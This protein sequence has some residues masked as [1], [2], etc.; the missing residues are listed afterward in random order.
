MATACNDG[1]RVRRIRLLRARRAN[2]A[3]FRVGQVVCD[4]RP[5][6]RLPHAAGQVS[7]GGEWFG[8]RMSKQ[9]NGMPDAFRFIIT[10]LLVLVCLTMRNN[11]VDETRAAH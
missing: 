8:M 4:G 7:V 9:W 2:D 1:R 3:A 5:D 11:G 10:L 6:G